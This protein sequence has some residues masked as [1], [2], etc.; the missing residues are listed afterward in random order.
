[1]KY[2][3]GVTL[4]QMLVVVASGVAIL[5]YATGKKSEQTI[6]KNEAQL[7][8]KYTSE[9]ELKKA[10]YLEQQNQLLANYEARGGEQQ[11]DNLSLPMRNTGYDSTNTGV[12]KYSG[13]VPAL[14]FRDLNRTIELDVDCNSPTRNKNP[15]KNCDY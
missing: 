2:Q 4:V 5:M 11:Q 1:M 7:I 9:N 15:F 10:E 13:P 6:Q 14:T 8:Q 12:E 3:R